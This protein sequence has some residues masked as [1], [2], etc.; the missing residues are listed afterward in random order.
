MKTKIKITNNLPDMI[1]KVAKRVLKNYPNIKTTL[2]YQE[3]H[4]EKRY[5]VI[6]TD[7]WYDG[8]YL[9]LTYDEIWR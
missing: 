1:S 3:T 6:M 2:S 4:Y 7:C 8:I 9:H 5:T